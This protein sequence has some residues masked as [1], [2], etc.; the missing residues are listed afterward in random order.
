MMSN[1]THPTFVSVGAMNRLMKKNRY[2][3]REARGNGSRPGQLA[4]PIKRDGS[5]RPGPVYRWSP[6]RNGWTFLREAA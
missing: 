2:A 3:P 6:T 5:A 4:E 1:P